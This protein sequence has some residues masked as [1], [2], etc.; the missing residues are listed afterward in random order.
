MTRTIDFDQFR[1]EQKNEPVEF[2]IGGKTYALPPAMPASIAVDIM[3]MQDLFEN[4][5][6]DVPP[7]VMEQIGK[8]LFGETM[9]KELLAEHR[10]TVDEIP[11][12][13]EKVLEAYTEPPKEEAETPTSATPAPSSPSSSRGRRSKRTS[14]ESTESTFAPV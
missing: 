6:A 3:S 4:D 2:I 14:S 12:L 11:V 8:S 7:E 13:M 1:A 10:I 5:D 9:W